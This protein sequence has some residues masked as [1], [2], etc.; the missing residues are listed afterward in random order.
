MINLL[1]PELKEQYVYGRRNTVLR[2]WAIAV[3]CGLAGVVVVTFAGLFMMEKSIN[4]YRSQVAQS[5]QLLTDQQLDQTRQHAKDITASVKLAVDVLSKEI[6]FSKLITQVGKVTPPNTSLTDLNIGKDSTSLD[7]KAISL[8]YNSA[9]QLQ[10]NLQDPANKIFS[11]ADIQ[12]ITCNDSAADPKHPC[13]IT[14]KALFN[15][16]NPFLFI[17][18]NGANK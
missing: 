6:M 16:S 8:D 12:T 2:R 7:I 10:V 1:P 18:K 9:T 13:S 5:D 17:N 3:T 14:I 15:Q 11:K 4:H